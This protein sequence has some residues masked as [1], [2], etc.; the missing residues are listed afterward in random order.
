MKQVEKN[1][2]NQISGGVKAPVDGGGCI[3]EA[4]TFPVFPDYPQFPTAPV[5]MDNTFQQV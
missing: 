5:D 3:P 4:P 1:D 2:T